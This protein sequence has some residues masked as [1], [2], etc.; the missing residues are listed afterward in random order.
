[1]PLESKRIPQAAKRQK[2][3]C[4]SLDFLGKKKMDSDS[5]DHQHGQRKDA[6]LWS[7]RAPGQPVWSVKRRIKQLAVRRKTATAELSRRLPAA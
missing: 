6:A 7:Y 2:S 4:R 3:M 5:S 1:M